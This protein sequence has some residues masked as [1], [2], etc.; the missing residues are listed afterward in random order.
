MPGVLTRIATSP[1][2][3]TP[4]HWLKVTW[5]LVLCSEAVRQNSSFR[6]KIDLQHQLFVLSVWWTHPR[7][8]QNPCAEFCVL[9]VITW[10]SPFLHL[11]LMLKFQSDS[12]L[13]VSWWIKTYFTL[14][15]SGPGE[16]LKVIC[17]LQTKDSPTHR[18]IFFCRSR[19]CHPWNVLAPMRSAARNPGVFCLLLYLHLEQIARSSN[20]KLCHDKMSKKVGITPWDISS[21]LQTTQGKTSVTQMLIVNLK[22]SL[23]FQTHKRVVFSTN[24]QLTSGRSQNGFRLLSLL[25]L[26]ETLSIAV[27]YFP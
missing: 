19:V 14:N 6:K 13:L 22:Y 16:K 1:D 23:A 15:S 21:R 18:N 4:Y 17:V 3:R 10:F 9:T 11:L 25:C 12:N 27:S 7:I 5:A 26:Q 8:K 24:Y 20:A 2:Q